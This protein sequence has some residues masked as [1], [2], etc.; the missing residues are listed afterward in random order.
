[1]ESFSLI[2]EASLGD[3]YR[4]PQPITMQGCGIQFRWIQLQ[5]SRN[6]AEEGQ[7]EPEDQRIYCEIVSPSNT[8]TY[9]CEVSPIWLPEYELNRGDI[10]EHAR[11]DEEKPMRPQPYR[12]NY[13]NLKYK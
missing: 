1:M 8:R 13:K 9:A 12:E 4:K 7:K 6:I 10:S 11:L 2:R 3:H 5:S